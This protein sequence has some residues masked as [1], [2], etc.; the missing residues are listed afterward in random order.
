MS[1]TSLS[2][3][4]D[5]YISARRLGRLEKL[6]KEAEKQRNALQG[7]AAALAL[8]EAENREQLALETERYHPANWLD[9]AARRARQISLVTHAPK[10]THSDAK[11]T[12]VMVTQAN[13]QSDYLATSSLR[14]VRIDVVG[15]AA[16]LDVANL[17]LL[18]TEGER[19]VD[20][21]ARGDPAPL[22]PFA[23]DEA[24]L[25]EWLEGF[26][27]A[28]QSR[29]PGS[30][31]L[32]KQL[33]FPVG[34]DQ[35]H[36]L[37]PLFSSSLTQAL[38]E[39]ID[40][41]RFSEEAKVARKARREGV[42]SVTATM[43]FPQLAVQSFGGTKPQNVSLLNS[44]RRGRAYLLNCRPPRWQQQQKAPGKDADFWRQYGWRVSY[45]L[46]QLKRYLLS[47]VDKD[48]TLAIRQH[49]AEL[50]AELVAE[51]HQFAAVLKMQTAGW[52][53][54][55]ELSEPFCHWLDPDN[56]EPEAMAARE[57]N[58]WQD[59][60]GEHFA[61]W[62]NRQLQHEQLQMK[63]V[64]YHV[65]RKIVTRELRLLK[66]DLEVLA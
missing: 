47:V 3:A 27:M 32:A 8:W 33:Y 44:G 48:S 4:I 66:E 24:Q 19:L 23:R 46:K 62:L 26:G 64:E 42:Y 13:R 30:H 52:S 57:R 10:Y 12:G 50:V 16:A 53:A 39:R 60:I 61:R 43:E 41:A 15:N 11:G 65:W 56:P 18:E 49:R 20:W 6:E 22:Q 2:S 31:K 34:D 14:D 45:S 21:L 37:G 36:L 35:Y 9:D 63:D 7:E 58:D 54:K 40:K 28:L 55:T 51:L 1:D 17:L 25:S 38:H 59:E 5:D 29:E